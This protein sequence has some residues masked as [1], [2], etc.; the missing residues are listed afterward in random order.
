MGTV[1]VYVNVVVGGVLSSNRVNV[2]IW[3]STE[4]LTASESTPPVA[5]YANPIWQGFY[6]RAK[7]TVVGGFDSNHQPCARIHISGWERPARIRRVGG[8]YHYVRVATHIIVRSRGV[9]K[10]TLKRMGTRD[11]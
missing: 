6:D 5:S 4:A 11:V 2:T 1:T 9:S 7:G 8:F 3:P 10:V